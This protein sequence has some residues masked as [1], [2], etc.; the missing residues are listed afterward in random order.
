M[1]NYSLGERLYWEKII[2]SGGYTIKELFTIRDAA[3]ILLNLG[4]PLSNLL[5]RTKNEIELKIK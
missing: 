3:S 5:E 1:S 2:T 4:L